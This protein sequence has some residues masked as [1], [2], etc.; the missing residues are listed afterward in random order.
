MT[1]QV[2]LRKRWGARLPNTVVS[3]SDARAEYLE[4]LGIGKVLDPKPKRKKA[5]AEN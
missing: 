1:M 5:K 3:V 2:K 4:K